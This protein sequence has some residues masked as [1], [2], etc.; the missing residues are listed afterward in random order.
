MS[1][2]FAVV[3]L[4]A[5]CPMHGYEL[6]RALS[7]A[8][9]RGRRVNDGILYPLLGKM[10]KEGLIRKTVKPGDGAPNRH[11]F[12]PTAKGRRVFREW[13]RGSELEEDEVSYDFLLGHPFLIKCMFFKHLSAT[14]MR[15]KL[16][17]HRRTAA[18]KLEAFVEIRKGMMKRKV[19]PFRIAILDLGIAQQREK[20]RWLDKLIR[21]HRRH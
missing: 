14:E 4:L 18:G 16:M 5:D 20:I 17:T 6:K 12:R 1:L 2:K 3:G 8:L 11:V 15:E 9:P 7:P 13:L 19:E 21:N 10:E